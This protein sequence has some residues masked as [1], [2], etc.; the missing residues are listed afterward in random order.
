LYAD[1]H[2]LT[3][4]QLLS[5]VMRYAEGNLSKAAKYLGISRATLR[6]RLSA[7]GLDMEGAERNRQ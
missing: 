1:L 3:D 5:E 7:L 4:R 2:A 6:S